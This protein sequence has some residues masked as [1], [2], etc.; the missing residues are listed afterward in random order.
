MSKDKQ[1]ISRLP[2]VSKS[3]VQMERPFFCEHSS[4]VLNKCLGRGECENCDETHFQ[5]SMD[6]GRTLRFCD[7]EN[8]KHAD[9]V[10]GGEVMT[11]F[12]EL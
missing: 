1:Q 11:M 9:L 2:P 8:V 12:A 7:T 6:N 3:K 5:I 4:A 10:L